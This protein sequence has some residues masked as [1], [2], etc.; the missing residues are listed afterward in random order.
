[1]RELRLA[2]LAATT[3][4]A[5]AAVP[6]SD[7]AASAS[8]VQDATT[9]TRVVVAGD[10]A[11]TE[12]LD[13]I[14]SDFALTLDPDLTLT[15]GDNHN[16]SSGT[17]GSSAVDDY[18][19][20]FAPTWGRLP[21][22]KPA[23]GNHDYLTNGGNDYLAYFGVP[24]YY[25]FD[26]PGWHLVSLNS[27]LKDDAFKAQVAWLRADLASVAAS[28]SVLAYWHYPRFSTAKHGG[29]T[30]VQPLWDALAN[31][32]APTLVMNGHNHVYE[33][34]API[35]GITELVVSTGGGNPECGFDTTAPVQPIVKDDCNGHVADLRLGGDGGWSMTAYRISSNGVPTA[36]DEVG[37]SAPPPTP[38]SPSPS[39][40]PSPAPSPPPPSPSPALQ[41]QPGVV[42]IQAG[43]DVAAVLAANPPGT[44]YQIA[45]GEFVL[46]APLRPEDGDRVI[47]AGAGAT[48]LRAAT[49]HAFDGIDGRSKVVGVQVSGLTVQGFD[50]GIST[51][52][53]WRVEGIEAFDNVIGVHIWGAGVIVTDSSVHHNDRIGINGN[54][55]APNAAVVG[56]DVGFNARNWD[57]GYA[58]GI[59]FTNTSGAVV[60]DNVVHDSGSNGIWFDEGLLGGVIRGNQT[61]ANAENGIRIEISSGTLIEGNTT[62]DGI[63]V[64]NSQSVVVK[65]N[66]ISAP[67]TTSQPL[68]FLGSGRI[69]EGVEMANVDNA[70]IG[71]VVT[72]VTGQSVGVI[73]LAGTTA[74]NRFES[75]TYVVPTSAG[76]YFKWS[77]GTTKTT[78]AF[79]DWQ[80]RY[81]QDLAGAL[82]LR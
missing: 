13:S 63:D 74:R 40:T 35:S 16:M 23:P 24:A 15:L 36:F 82:R 65:S 1:M 50:A 10:L 73:R 32:S 81:G 62:S 59:R 30:K 42:T 47:G 77:S 22:I 75:N 6:L 29:M 2:A 80:S 56:N 28:T 52:P 78:V 54:A 9:E 76:R 17:L 20:L 69:F 11:T 26:V 31:R 72:L 70:A 51:G 3:M 79:A 12:S 53:G 71:N 4:L 5:L 34:Y 46:S 64:V 55:D 25:S 18:Q 68:R 21:N 49:P 44:T 43:T 8:T 7:A 61:W 45:A 39:P 33:R 60:T 37:A 14:V 48:V 58:A 67:S 57:P 38:P 27:Q 66:T 41:A 19:R